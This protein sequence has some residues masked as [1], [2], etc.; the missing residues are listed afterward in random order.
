MPP[1]IR[2][3]QNFLTSK[4]LAITAIVF[5][6]TTIGVTATVQ[7]QQLLSEKILCC[8]EESCQSNQANNT[9][10]KLRYLSA[11]RREKHRLDYNCMNISILDAWTPKESHQ[12][13]FRPN[14][15][16]CHLHFPLATLLALP[17]YCTAQNEHDLWASLYN[18]CKEVATA[19]S[20]SKVTLL[21]AI[22]YIF[23]IQTRCC[24]CLPRKINPITQDRKVSTRSQ[25]EWPEEHGCLK[26]G[27]MEKWN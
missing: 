7:S 8:K 22:E 17:P 23:G 14:I 26:N 1:E 5:A 10:H 21:C 4:A 15:Q 11:E 16:I 24:H 2:I 3:W 18:K 20:C 6:I 19:K 12:P 13:N 25:H 9:S 27:Q